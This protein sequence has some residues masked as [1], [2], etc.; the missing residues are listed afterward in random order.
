MG[1]LCGDYISIL[2]G[3]FFESVDGNRE[4][5]DFVNEYGFRG[6]RLDIIC[7]GLMLDDIAIELIGAVPQPVSQTFML[8]LVRKVNILCRFCG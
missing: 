6:I 1:G 4:R 2:F 3:P 8:E 7:R 5:L